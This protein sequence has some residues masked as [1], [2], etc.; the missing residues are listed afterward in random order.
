MFSHSKIILAL[1]LITRTIDSDVSVNIKQGID[2]N[3]EQNNQIINQ[4]QKVNK[5]HID[6]SYF[7]VEFMNFFVEFF[8]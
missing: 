2:T 6:K 7:F 1:Q 3:G 4:L 8:C 5:Q